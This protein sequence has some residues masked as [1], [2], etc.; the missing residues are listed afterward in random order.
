MIGRRSCRAGA[1]RGFAADLGRKPQ[2]SCVGLPG[3][4]GVVAKVESVRARGRNGHARLEEDVDVRLRNKAKDGGKRPR[5]HARLS[6]WQAAEHISPAVEPVLNA[7]SAV[8]KF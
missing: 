2:Q 3:G 5:Q 4:P 7:R 6:T 1:D 8:Q